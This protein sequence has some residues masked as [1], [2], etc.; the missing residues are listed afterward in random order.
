MHAAHTGQVEQFAVDSHVTEVP[1]WDASQINTDEAGG[2]QQIPKRYRGNEVEHAEVNQG[3]QS[4]GEDV[5]THELQLNMSVINNKVPPRWE[6]H[7]W[8]KP[9][10][11]RESGQVTNK[12]GIGGDNQIASPSSDATSRENRDY[13]ESEE[14]GIEVTDSEGDSD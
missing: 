2:N 1:F 4:D 7:A 8:W 6:A 5:Q 9:L 11:H 14:E 10:D 3:N 12:K 13:S